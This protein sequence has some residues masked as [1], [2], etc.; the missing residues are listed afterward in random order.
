MILILAHAGDAVAHRLAAAWSARVVTARDLSTRGWRH[1]PM[2]GGEDV[3]GLA[4]GPL[5]A[6]AVRG[7]LTRVGAIAPGDLGHIAEEDRAYV[8]AEMTAF[9]LSFLRGLRCPV[10]ARPTASSLMG[11]GWTTPRWRAA[12]VA[13]GLG[14][15]PD[16]AAAEVVTV[17]GEEAFGPAALAAPALALARH[18]GVELL[19]ARFTPAGQF[20]DAHPWA[21]LPAAAAAAVRARFA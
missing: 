10:L 4:D 14:V 21:E 19:I 6:S 8:A 3:L 2:G 12:A 20:V 11:P 17:V 15:A 13:A 9:L 5:P 16:A 7:V 1:S 18:A